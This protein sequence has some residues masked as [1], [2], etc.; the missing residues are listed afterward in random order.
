M[1]PLIALTA[2]TVLALIARRPPLLALRLGIAAM[3]VVTGAAHFIGMR[4]ELIAMVP[5]WLP[6]P[7]LLVTITGAL[8]LAGAVGVVLPAT[9][10]WAAAGLGTLLVA[11]FPANV[12]LALTNPDLPFT[13]QLVPR[14]V[15]QLIFLAATTTVVVAYARTRRSAST[16]AAD[17]IAR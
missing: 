13:Q 16:D 6:A 17:L 14:T 1:P 3:F 5:P 10:P 11:M 9:A 12:H 4:E 2:V 15:I 8:E 7:E